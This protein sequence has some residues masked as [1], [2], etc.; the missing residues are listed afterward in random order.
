MTERNE[1]DILRTFAKHFAR[2]HKI[3][4]HNALNVIAM[5]YGHPHWVALVKAWD[6]GWRPTPWELIDINECKT[7]ESP[8][9]GIGSVKTSKGVIAGEP[10]TLEVGFD[11]VL[12]GGRGWAI[13]LGHAPSEAAEIE[14]YTQP[15]PLDDKTFFSHVMKIAMEAIDEVREAIRK[16][17][18]S[19]SMQPDKNGSAKHPLFGGISTEWV[20]LHCNTH[21]T[22][23]AI[24]S[25]MWHCPKCSATPLD[26][27]MTAW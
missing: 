10:Y 15:N 11:D 21:S 4:R 18:G 3:P 16:D 6:K 5:Q 8:I 1:L 24:A 22:S 26:I 25:N 14:Q 27:H 20:C 2:K 23:A 13:H 19:D 12:I 17:W 9:R 7:I